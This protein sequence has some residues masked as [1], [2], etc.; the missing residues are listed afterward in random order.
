MPPRSSRAGDPAGSEEAGVAAEN[1]ER[2]LHA[3]EREIVAL[4]YLLAIVPLFGILI[5]GIV[6]ENNT[7]L[8]T[9]NRKHFERIEGLDLV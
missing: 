8:L 2:T 1:T 4:T 7:R 6:V 5:A 3:R 9:R